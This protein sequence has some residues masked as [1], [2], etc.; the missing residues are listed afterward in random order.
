M[1]IRQ[2][3][4]S[5]SNVEVEKGTSRKWTPGE[6]GANLNRVTYPATSSKIS[7]LVISIYPPTCETTSMMS[8]IEELSLRRTF[9][10]TGSTMSACFF[11]FS[12]W[13]MPL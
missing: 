7:W 9:G 4:S 2:A 3:Y 13:C 5:L 12:L 6:K 11:I 10:D 1:D 8:S